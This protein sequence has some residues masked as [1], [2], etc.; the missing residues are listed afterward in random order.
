MV[1]AAA[2]VKLSK[3]VAKLPNPWFP[4]PT[5]FCDATMPGGPLGTKLE[6]WL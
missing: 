1:V 3:A 6:G 4:G 5:S 2:K